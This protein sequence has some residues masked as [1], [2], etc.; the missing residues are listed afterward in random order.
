[1]KKK[2]TKTKK[3]K[4]SASD[5]KLVKKM[6]MTSKESHKKWME[7]S[8]APKEHKIRRKLTPEGKDIQAHAE[9][10]EWAQ[11]KIVKYLKE[12]KLDPKKTYENDP[13][14]GPQLERYYRICRT[15]DMK[16][17]HT[18]M[19]ART[20]EPMR[21]KMKK[22]DCQPKVK[23]VRES[24]VYDYPDIEGKPMSPELR[25][26]YRQKMRN[27]VKANMEKEKAEQLALEFISGHRY[28][29]NPEQAIEKAERKSE[30]LQTSRHEKRKRAREEKEVQKAIDKQ[31]KLDVKNKFK[32]IKTNNKRN[33][34][35]D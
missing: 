34:D 23:T 21:K 9:R 14:H 15:A 32:K 3:T 28:V 4:K 8:E 17:A 24:L 1:M 22:P 27:L 25:K 6:K 7:D 12:H 35:E 19:S 16:Q 30:Q 13:V 20:E 33:R 31:K 29:S 10:A 2:D 18:P 26:R 11:K 5:E